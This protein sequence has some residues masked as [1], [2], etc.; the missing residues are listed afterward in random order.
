MTLLDALKATRDWVA[1]HEWIQGDWC[2]VLGTGP[3]GEVFGYCLLGSVQKVTT[4][5]PGGYMRV[6]DALSEYLGSLYGWWSSVADWNDREGRT[7]DEV[8][9][10]LD[11]LITEKEKAA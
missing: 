8:L 9:V 3:D 7:K 10:L 2:R 1:D 6:R 5:Y 11:E 4:E